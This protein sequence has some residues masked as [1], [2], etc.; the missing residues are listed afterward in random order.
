M[1]NV[2]TG[3][4]RPARPASP[5]PEKPKKKSRKLLILLILLLLLIAVG[6]GAVI[7]LLLR[8]SDGLEMDDNA[9]V[10]ILP[11]IDLDQRRAEL[12][13]E[14]DES[15]ISFSINTS[16]VFENGGAAGNLML[17]NPGN[18][19]KLLV[20]EIYA[21][22]TGELLY[23]SKA[24]PTGSYIETARLDKV[25]GPGEYAATAYF[26]AYREDDQSYIGQTGAAIKITVLS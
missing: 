15:M 6:I 20:V 22:D 19:A 2:Q 10:G 8:D 12:Q 17:E 5:R 14:L 13:Q 1:E 23:K 3:N 11:G 24:I 9:T 7:Y 21:D 16:P 25:L 4:V 18:N 26:N